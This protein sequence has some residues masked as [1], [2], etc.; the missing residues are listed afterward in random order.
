PAYPTC[1]PVCTPQRLHHTSPIAA[2]QLLVLRRFRYPVFPS[3]LL[4]LCSPLFSFFLYYFFLYFFFQAEDGIRDFH[5]TG[6]QTCALPI[7]APQPKR[8]SAMRGTS[9]AARRVPPGSR[10]V[11]CTAA[12]PLS[13]RTA[14]MS[15]SRKQVEGD[16]KSVV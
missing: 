13:S 1:L 2:R 9:M 5:V 15:A 10:K 8:P 16:R 11:R 6:V 4:R 3:L 7:S 12:S 14:A